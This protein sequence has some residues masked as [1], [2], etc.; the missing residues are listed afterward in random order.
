VFVAGDWV[1]GE[2]LLLDAALASAE[3]AAEEAAA[4]LGVAK[5]A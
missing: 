4:G 1:G 3:Q 5:V 2:G